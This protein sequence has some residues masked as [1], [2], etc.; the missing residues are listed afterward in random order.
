MHGGVA[1]GRG[2]AAGGGECRV[3]ASPGRQLLWDAGGGGEDACGGA[4]RVREVGV[5]VV[6]VRLPLGYGEVEGFGPLGPLVG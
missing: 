3:Q 2:V 1:A 6:V 4:A 5:V